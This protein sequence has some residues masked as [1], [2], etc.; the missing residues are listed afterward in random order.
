MEKV[1]CDNC[2]KE[3]LISDPSANSNPPSFGGKFCSDK[4][5]VEWDDKMEDTSIEEME[6][7][8]ENPYYD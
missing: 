1:K 7:T 3:F 4:C 6:W 8:W 5:W 2:G